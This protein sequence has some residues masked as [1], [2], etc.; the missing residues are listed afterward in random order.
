[1]PKTEKKLL[2]SKDILDEIERETIERRQTDYCSYY[3]ELRDRKKIVERFALKKLYKLNNKFYT[4][5]KNKS[6]KNHDVCKKHIGIDSIDVSKLIFVENL[7]EIEMIK[8]IKDLNNHQFN[9]EVNS[10]SKS[11]AEKI[12]TA[13]RK[14]KDAILTEIKPTQIEQT[15]QTIIAK[16]TDISRDIKVTKSEDE[17]SEETTKE[18]IVK[19]S[20]DEYES[21]DSE[22]SDC[23]VD[24]IKSIGGRSYYI[25]RKLEIIEQD[26]DGY[27]FIAGRL[28]LTK[29]KK[30]NVLYKDQKY[31]IKKI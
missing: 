27:G 2:S 15:I 11:K 26:D 16:K 7:G 25:N 18:A 14:R 1:M 30:Y 8:D 13:L 28:E 21:S 20:S 4:N 10:L 9:I 19:E 17:I 5:C 22:S 24:S 12:L 6:E 3:F 31:L 23:S 29:S